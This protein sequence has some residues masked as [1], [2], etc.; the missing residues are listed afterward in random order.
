MGKEID[1][2]DGLFDRID[3]ELIIL[4]E[5]KTKKSYKWFDFVAA[6][7]LLNDILQ[8]EGYNEYRTRKVSRLVNVFNDLCHTIVQSYSYRVLAYDKERRVATEEWHIFGEKSRVE[9]IERPVIDE[10]EE[11]Y[12]SLS[13]PEQELHSSDNLKMTKIKYL[14]SGCDEDSAELTSIY[15]PDSDEMDSSLKSLKAEWGAIA[16]NRD[17]LLSERR[18]DF[19]EIFK[20][21]SNIIYQHKID[22]EKYVKELKVERNILGGTIKKADT[23]SNAADYSV[24]MDYVERI[25]NYILNDAIPD[26]IT[27]ITF[28]NCVNTANF[29]AIWEISGVK[30]SKL[31]YTIFTLSKEMPN[32]WYK[33]AANSIGLTPQK[34]S[35]A[36]VPVGWDRGI[37]NIK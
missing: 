26:T 33:Q 8:N 10:L 7:R 16:L 20:M 29:S 28:L 4:Y 11:Y 18:G 37:R 14:L 32:E 1:T 12:E 19:N 35:G 22:F 23:V 9:N 24:N 13:L 30:K 3:D 36:T 2:I 15:Y 5:A 17:Q 6:L 34:C 25:Y 21:D 27:N 31:K